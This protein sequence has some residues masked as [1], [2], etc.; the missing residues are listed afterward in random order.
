MKKLQTQERLML[1]FRVLPVKN[2]FSLKRAGNMS[3]KLAER[4]IFLPERRK[5]AKEEAMQNKLRIYQK[6]EI[7][8]GN[9]IHM[10]PNGINEESR[11]KIANQENAGGSVKADSLITTVPGLAL[12]LA[13]ADCYPLLVTNKEADILALIHVGLRALLD[14]II[15]KTFRMLDREMEILSQE[16]GK[17]IDRS[18]LMVGIGPGICSGCYSVRQVALSGDLQKK[19]RDKLRER[20][21]SDLRELNL[22]LAGMMKNDLQKEQIPLRKIREINFCTCCSKNKQREGEHLFFSHKRAMD[23]EEKEGR[24]LAVASL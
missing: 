4:L 6:L 13:P 17:K 1:D 18:D 3:K 14:K 12:E 19:Y 8:F 20:G 24:I 16:L 7:P 22:T 2:G 23:N 15:E 21:N 10:L 11:V 5:R 9:V